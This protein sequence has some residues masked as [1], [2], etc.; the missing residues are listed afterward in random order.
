VTLVTFLSLTALDRLAVHIEGETVKEGLSRVARAAAGLVDADIHSLLRKPQQRFSPQYRRALE[1]LVKFHRDIPEIA[2]LYTLAE[3]DGKM[4]YILDTAAAAKELGFN[5]PMKVSEIM[6]V[7][8]SD[9]PEEDAATLAAVR[10]GSVYVSKKVFTDKYGTFMSAHAPIRDKSGKVIGLLG[11]DM[12]VKEYV[13]RIQGLHLV[14]AS[15]FAI[16]ALAG[17]VLGVVVYRN[18]LR[19]LAAESEARQHRKAKSL[20]EEGHARL[21]MALGEV[22][23]QHRFPEDDLTWEGNTLKI[24]GWEPAEMPRTSAAWLE[25]VH[26]DE[27]E[28]VMAAYSKAIRDGGLYHDEYRFQAKGGHY[29]WI[30]DRGVMSKDSEDGT[31]TVD[32]V[33]QDISAKKEADEV[34][35]LLALVAE[36]TNNIVI[37]A[38]QYGR[39]EW[40]NKSFT[41]VTEYELPEVKGRSP[42]EVLAGPESDPGARSVMRDAL[43]EG[44]GFKVEIV[45]Y[46]K[47]GR[48]YWVA[49]EVLPVRN[50]KG[51]ITNY[52]AVESEITRQKEFE[53]ELIAAKET[54]EFANRA[55]SEFLAVMSHEIRTPMN[56]VIGFSQLLLETPLNERQRD[57]LESIVSSGDSLLRLLNDILDFSKMESGKMELEKAPFSLCETISQ[58]AMLHSPEADRKG[59]KLYID[60]ADNMVDWITGDRTRFRQVLVN[61]VGN[62][63]KFTESGAVTIRAAAQQREIGARLM[64]RISVRDTGIGISQEE[65]T[66]LFKPFSQADSSTTRRYGGTGLGLAICARLAGLLDGILEVESE[67]GKGSEFSLIVPIEVAN[68]PPPLENKFDTSTLTLSAAMPILV[69]EDNPVNQK[70]IL[71]MLESIGHSADVVRNGADC[72]AAVDSKHYDMIFMDLQMPEMD[73]YEAT[74]RLR[75]K[76]YNVWIT[77][78]TADAMPEDPLRSRI[79]GMNDYLSKPFTKHDLLTAIERCRAAAARIS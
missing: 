56:G 70:V 55:K 76:G 78:L 62:A 39:I 7:A 13:R 1:P 24:L 51:E 20:L 77:A 58:V 41:D 17:C 45:N 18:R 23:Y 73:G 19:A 34:I 31:I 43:A 15:G 21:T 74:A 10:S 59:V 67:L 63:V 65:L 37:L 64:L 50:A 14:S 75:G 53:T 26:P 72:L 69:A 42:G 33:M 60:F 38:D 4:V 9:S 48:K 12:D 3:S 25:L 54:A 71:R 61:L 22:L 68:E 52:L 30:R 8:D 66:R 79:A 35:E 27:R 6:E 28:H 16:S 32:G 29:V 46:S 2:Y 44:R 36:K 49:I 47:S 40:V 11:I 5:R 57:Y